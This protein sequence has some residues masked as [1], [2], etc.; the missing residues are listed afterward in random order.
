MKTLLGLIAAILTFAQTS[1]AVWIDSK[2]HT[3]GE[4]KLFFRYLNEIDPASFSSAIQAD[5]FGASF[6]SAWHSVSGSLHE[7]FVIWDTPTVDREI[8]IFATLDAS[9][10][11]SWASSDA[12]S[13]EIVD[14]LESP[15][16]TF[17]IDN[18]FD[19]TLPDGGST[20][21]MLLGAGIASAGLSRKA[22]IARR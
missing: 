22:N 5:E 8:R 4:A 20:M 16:F 18:P 9:G 17:R 12:E 6:L 3:T 15:L 11:H 10:W 2:K 13:I 21:L 19:P 1:S 14:G 7:F